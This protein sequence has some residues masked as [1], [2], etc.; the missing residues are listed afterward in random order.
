MRSYGLEPRE[1][2]VVVCRIEPENNVDV[3]V[4]AFSRVKTTKKLAIVGGANYESPYLAGM[5][6]S[7]PSNVV[8][9]G[10]V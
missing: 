8:F 9:L 4:D 5:K 3:I 6:G 7:A 1:Y 10:P 2:F